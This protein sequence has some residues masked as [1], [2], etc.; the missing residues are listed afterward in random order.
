MIQTEVFDT[1]EDGTKLIKTYSD[2]G[3][4]IEQVETGIR[5]AEAIDPDF[6][7]REYTETDEP[8]PVE[9]EEIEEV[10]AE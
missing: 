8:I 2:Q 9:E 1:W 6:M 4:M 5:Y 10:E 7:N 3:M